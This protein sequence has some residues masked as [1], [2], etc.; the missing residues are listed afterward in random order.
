MNGF[1][2]E[3]FGDE[4]DPNQ[5]FVQCVPLQVLFIQIFASEEKHALNIVVGMIEEQ[6]S[7]R[8][9]GVSSS[10]SLFKYLRI[11]KY[12][13]V[14]KYLLLRKSTWNTV[15]RIE[16]QLAA[17]CLGVSS[18]LPIFKYLPVLKYLPVFKYLPM[19]KY[20]PVFK[21]LLQRKS[22]GLRNS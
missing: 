5:L 10:L 18:S 1:K 19:F 12:L 2:L 16:E 4:V 8:C 14:F 22:A 17:R 20:L 21:Y 7:A 6:L 15:G 11:F 13:P 3:V 9:L